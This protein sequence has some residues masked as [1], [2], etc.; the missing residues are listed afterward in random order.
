[1]QEVSISEWHNLSKK[2][3]EKVTKINFPGTVVDVTDRPT[4]AFA[5]MCKNEEHCIGKT[6]ECVSPYVD[7]IVVADNGSTDKTFEIVK[8]FFEKTGIPGAW[9][10]DPWDGYAINKT[11]M[12]SY[13]KDK[14]DYLLH[15]DADDFLSG[16]F[17]FTWE[18]A[19]KDLYNMILKRGSLSWKA[20]VLYNNR[21]TWRFIGTAHT[22]IKADDKQHCVWGDLTHKGFIDANGIGSRSFDPKKFWYDG[23]RLTK[24]FWECL[25]SDPDNLLTRSAFY[26]GQSYMD[27]GK[28]VGDME[29]VEKG[30]QWYKLFLNFKGTWIEEQFEAQMRIASCM[31]ILPQSNKNIEG[32]I[33]QMEKA[34]RIFD[35]RAEP[36]YFLGVYLCQMKQ[37]ELAYQY[38][39]KAKACPL[40]VAEEKYHLFVNVYAYNNHINDWLSVACYWTNRLEEGRALIKE[41]LEDTEFKSRTEH[42]HRNLD[43][44]DKLEKS[45]TNA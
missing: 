36:Y 35:D 28:Q 40:K 45:L 42:F 30:L 38:L 29:C 14:T 44:F 4:L 2:D 43:L 33:N 8:E 20:T 37:H 13:A 18:D 34:I 1:M 3:K 11:K 7:Y 19:G 24:Q 39:K 17:S 26:A 31:M 9:H 21:L 5:T 25:S 10:L 22:V 27:Y 15:V 41:V 12:M 23:E 6:L 16:D 32:I